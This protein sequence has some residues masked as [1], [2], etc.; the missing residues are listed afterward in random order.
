[1]NE[2]TQEDLHRFFRTQDKPCPF[3]DGKEWGVTP[4]NQ[5]IMMLIKQDD[6]GFSIPPLHHAGYGAVCLTCGFMRVHV[7][8]VVDSWLANHPKKAE[9]G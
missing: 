9:S 3:C 4:H 8:E 5:Q 1:M 6:G 2:I 7:A